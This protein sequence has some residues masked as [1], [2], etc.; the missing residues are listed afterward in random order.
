MAGHNKWSQIKHK[1][2]RV[3]KKRAKVWSTISRDLISAARS[4]GGDPS[5]NLK[6][7]WA[8][9]EARKHNMPADTIHRA[10]KR[11]TGELAGADPEEVI[12]EGYGPG[13]A[14]LLVIALTDNRH[15]TASNVRHAFDKKGGS[16]GTSGSVSYMFSTKGRVVIP[17]TAITEEGLFELALEAGADDVDSSDESNFEVL[18][19]PSALEPLKAALREKGVQWD[20]AERAYLPNVTNMIGAEDARKLMV[21]VDALED[22][23]DIQAVVGNFEI[24]DEV[25][26][27]LS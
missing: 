3:D 7:Q 18:C 10:I 19:D 16:F 14:A 23:D 4:G 24:P 13:G 21:L 8:M 15:R 22:D 25:L 1:K 9:A 20:T 26:A 5:H 6:L 2:A 17:K 27:E 12:Y 11:G